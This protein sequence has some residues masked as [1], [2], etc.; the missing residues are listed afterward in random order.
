MRYSRIKAAMLGL[1]PQRRNRR[2]S[3]A[4][5]KDTKSIAVQ[6]KDAEAETPF[7]YGHQNK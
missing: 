2:M 3:K 5:G 6:S 1:K 4:K 7:L